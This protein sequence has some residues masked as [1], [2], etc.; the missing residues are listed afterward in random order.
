MKK[1]KN[2]LKSKGGFSYIPVCIF[3][4]VVAMV[5]GM[6]MQYAF[7]YHVAREQRDE[8]QLSL[9]S[10]VTK[11]AIEYYDA[12]KQGKPYRDYIDENE[13]VSGAY[14]KIGFPRGSNTE[15]TPSDNSYVMYRP[16]ISPLSGNSVGV[17]VRY[18]LSI[19][20]ELWGRKIADI[21]IPVE[22]V[23]KLT[24]RNG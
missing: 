11:E 13:L 1:V 20:F 21:T 9:D 16:T 3:T 5:I 19:P 24:E 18:T 10:Y 6:L 15:Y 7:I 14:S 23:S 17:N 8:I 4:L 12:F 22:I 2:A